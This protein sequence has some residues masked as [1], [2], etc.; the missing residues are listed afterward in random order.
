[1]PDVDYSTPTKIEN[2]VLVVD[3]LRVEMRPDGT[4]VH[5]DGSPRRV[6]VRDA[7]MVPSMIEADPTDRRSGQQPAT[8]GW[9]DFRRDGSGAWR[10]Q[11]R[12]GRRY[13]LFQSDDGSVFRVSAEEPD[14]LPI[15]ASRAARMGDRALDHD[16]VHAHD[17]GRHQL[18]LARYAQRLADYWK[19]RE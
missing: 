4:H 3:D 18:G 6:K 14:D 15:G 8:A 7:A 16:L 1:M 2:G 17:E 9:L 11:D 19:R 10:A 5:L 12:Q 13:R